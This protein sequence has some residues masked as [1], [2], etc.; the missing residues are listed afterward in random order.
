MEHWAALLVNLAVSAS[1]LSV[2]ATTNQQ[3]STAVEYNLQLN[4]THQTLTMSVI[5]EFRPCSMAF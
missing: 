5:S 1:T 2:Y 4:E 3:S